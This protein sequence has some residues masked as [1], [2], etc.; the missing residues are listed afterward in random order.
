MKRG[1]C[2]LPLHSGDELIIESFACGSF[3][4]L[5]SL[6]VLGYS[7]FGHARMLRFAVPH[8]DSSHARL[9]TVR[10]VAFF[11]CVNEAAN[12]D[13]QRGNPNAEGHAAFSK[14]PRGAGILV[15]F[16][17]RLSKSFAY[18]PMLLFAVVSVNRF[19]T[20]FKTIGNVIVSK[21]IH[22][23]S[24]LKFSWGYAD[25]VHGMPL[26]KAWWEDNPSMK[27]ETLAWRPTSRQP[28]RDMA[29]SELVW[30]GCLNGETVVMPMACQR[31]RLLEPTCQ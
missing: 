9:K 27:T 10:F 15:V 16:L 30:P 17:I 7:L 2:T 29:A 8:I 26:Q 14:R 31:R 1:A 5:L 4:A 22:D 28:D 11:E 25:G 23:A 18:R 24:Q 12:L 13:F 3:G 6:G 21:Y 19:N 20:F